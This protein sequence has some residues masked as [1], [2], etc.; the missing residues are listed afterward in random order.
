MCMLLVKRLLMLTRHSAKDTEQI[1]RLKDSDMSKDF[2]AAVYQV[3]GIAVM[4]HGKHPAKV[5]GP[6]SGGNE[7]FS[8][9]AR[10]VL[11][12]GT[13]EVLVFRPNLISGN[14]RIKSLM[15]DGSGLQD[16]IGEVDIANLR[17]AKMS[18]RRAGK[19]AVEKLHQLLSQAENDP[20]YHEPTKRFIERIINEASGEDSPL[21]FIL[22]ELLS[23][24]RSIGLMEEA[25]RHNDGPGGS[26]ARTS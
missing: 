18:E 23:R 11:G 4:F 12:R 10:R 15:D 3:H 26:S 14:T 5:A 8:S 24:Q 13:D 7:T 2:R 21:D 6:L 19:V 22:R 20:G 16:L 9:W 25:Q 17:A 1:G